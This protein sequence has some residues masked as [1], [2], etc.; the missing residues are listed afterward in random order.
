[1]LMPMKSYV[2]QIFYIWQPY[3]LSN[4]YDQLSIYSLAGIFIFFLIYASNLK[5]YIHVYLQSVPTH[6]ETSMK[7]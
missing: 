4:N 7:C 3:L 5:L 1:M 6:N 2:T